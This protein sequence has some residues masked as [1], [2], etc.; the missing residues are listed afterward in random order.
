MNYRP[1][2]THNLLHNGNIRDVIN[3]GN[4]LFW[5]NRCESGDP[6]GLIKAQF[7]GLN[8]GPISIVYLTFGADVTIEPV[9]NEQHFIVQTTLSGQ[10]TT[11]NGR[12]VVLTKPS[13]IA[14][15][16]ASLPTKI[17]F[18]QGCAHLVLKIDRGLINLK[19]QALLQQEINQP[20]TF[21]LLTQP[22]DACKKAWMETMNFLCSFYDKPSPQILQNQHL[23]NSHIDMAACTLISSQ[24]HNYSER[25]NIDQLSAAPRHVRRVCEFID[26]N[27]KGVISMN[28]LCEVSKTTERTLQNAFRKYMGQTPT[29][30]IQSRRLHHLH[31]ALKNAKGYTNVSRIM[32]EHGINNPGRWA[33][34][35]F[36]RYGCYPSETLS[37]SIK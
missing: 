20:V 31:Q 12:R 36:K 33:Q 4:Q 19:L 34:L 8:L 37:G 21:D 28:E 11:Q 23:L 25:L 35:Y 16:D 13:D 15:I 18:K 7:N 10:S 27:I 1:L 2:A 32:W 14:V 24:P 30:F 6:G 9:C 5:Q 3:V 22:N 26:A 29:T 17:H